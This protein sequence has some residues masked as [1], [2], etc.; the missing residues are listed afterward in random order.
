MNDATLY[1]RFKHTIGCR[2]DFSTQGEEGEWFDLDIYSGFED[3]T[4]ALDDYLE[5][6]YEGDAEIKKAGDTVS[7]VDPSYGS[8]NIV[9]HYRLK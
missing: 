4:Q 8:G 3:P 1:A 2:V 7:V 5:G 9:R 6:E